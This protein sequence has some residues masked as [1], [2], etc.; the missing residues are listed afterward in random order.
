MTTALLP[1]TDA[2][3]LFAHGSRDP[4]WTR[5]VETL[6]ARIAMLADLPV[7]LA[8]LEHRAPSLPEAVGQ[9]VAEGMRRVYVVP[10][11]IGLGAHLRRDLPALVE[12]ARSAYPHVHV[13]LLAALGEQP[14]ILESMA[15]ALTAQIQD[16]RSPRM[17][18]QT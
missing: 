15:R 17:Y 5:P 8:Y 13:E 14:E 4:E 7:G 1:K 12:S 16:Q 6:R 18:P 3:V 2:L 11:F 10:V 9:M